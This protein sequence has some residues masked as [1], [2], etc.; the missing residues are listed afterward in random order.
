MAEPSVLYRIVDAVRARLA[1]V[2]AD[3]EYA[4]VALKTPISRRRRSLRAALA[5]DGPSIIAECKKA[6]PSAGLLR[7]DFD[8]VELAL[9]YQTAGAAAISVVTEPDF[10]HGR[11]EWLTAV[12]LAVDLPILRKDFI[13]DE[14]QLREAA[15]FGA[16]AVLLIQR[17]LP[18]GRLEDLVRAAA[19]L[20]LESLVE[21][22]T[23]EDPAPAVASG[24]EM[25]GVNARDLATFETRLDAV[26]SMASRL[27][28]DRI[29]VAESGISGHDEVAR[30]SRAGYDAF[31]V[32]EHLVRADDP[33]LALRRLRG[34]DSDD[35]ASE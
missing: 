26:E 15:A 4:E 31:L 12:R 11:V 2:P 18:A 33:E 22:F 16:D 32:G 20:G 19:E 35:S 24:S 30:L 21:I 1:T 25:I 5:V 13:I 34:Q 28:E 23:D 14:R 7:G 29:T 27:P 6:S 17:I 9:R 8:P 10:F 3:I